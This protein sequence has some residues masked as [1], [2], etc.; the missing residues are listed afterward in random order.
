MCVCVWGCVESRLT[1]DSRLLN[2][3]LRR[4]S[5]NAGHT[6]ADSLTLD[7][8]V[9]L[10]APQPHTY[11]HIQTHHHT[12]TNTHHHTHTHTITHTNTPRYS[13]SLSHTQTHTITMTD[14]SPSTVLLFRCFRAS[15]PWC[16][17]K[18]RGEAQRNN[19]LFFFV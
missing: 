13:L 18:E 17:T 8:Q 5:R 6:L 7:G 12:H 14:S 2:N 9:S 15:H 10:E 19:R 4:G 11:T 3:F 16:T 1:A